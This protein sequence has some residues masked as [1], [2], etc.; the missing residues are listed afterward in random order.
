VVVL[1]E[2]VDV[3]VLVVVDV[4]V[5]VLVV[6]VV[7]VVVV[8]VVVGGCGVALASTESGLSPPAF[9]PAVKAAETT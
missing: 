8:V 9:V 6:V 5:V 3:V 1:V 2:V 4:V 7:D